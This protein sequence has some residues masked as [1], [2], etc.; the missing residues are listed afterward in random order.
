[1]VLYDCE[2]LF[3]TL[4]EEHRLRVFEN[5]VLK[6]LFRPKGGEVTGGW[7]KLCNEEPCD[8]NSWS[9]VIRMRWVGHAARMGENRNAYRLLVGKRALGRPRRWLDNIK[10]D[11]GEIGQSGMD[12]IGLAW[13]RCKWKCAG[14]HAD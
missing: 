9:S 8:L 1:V 6:K 11:L 14:I 10:M 2:A 13:D 4:R 3:L 5:R 7:R 12:W